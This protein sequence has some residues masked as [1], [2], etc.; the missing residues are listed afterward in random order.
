MDN[1]CPSCL[2][3]NY[4]GGVCSNCGYS[5]AA[6]PMKP[7]HLRPRSILNKRY[8]VGKFIGEGGFG[9]TYAGWDEK[10][11]RKVAIKEYYPSGY[12]TR[13][14]SDGKTVYSSGEKREDFFD[15]GKERFVEEAGRLK[16]FQGYPGIVEV[17]DCFSE[18]GTVYIVMEFVEGTTLSNVL[19]SMGGKMDEALVLEL[20]RPLIKSLGKMHETGLIHRDIAPDN[21]MIQPN[22]T[23]KLIDFGAAKEKD[24]AGQSSMAVMKHGYSPEEQYG[25]NRTRQGAWT[26]VYALCATIYRAIEG[27]APPDA[28]DRMRGD[29]SFKGFTVS[30]KP[31][32]RYAV[33]KGLEVSPEKRLQSMGEL[34]DYLYNGKIPPAPP[35]PEPPMPEPPK[36]EPKPNSKRLIAILSAIGGVAV[37]VI[38]I[39]AAVI[40]HNHIIHNNNNNNNSTYTYH[41]QTPP[42]VATPTQEPTERPTAKPTEKPT[43]KPTEKPTQ[44]PSPSPTEEKTPEPSESPASKRT[45]T[46]FSDKVYE[47]IAND[48]YSEIAMGGEYGAGNGFHFRVTD[49]Q[50]LVTDKGKS[51]LAVKVTLKNTNSIDTITVD[52]YDFVCASI[53]GDTYEDFMTSAMTV[54]STADGLVNIDFPINVVAG[55]NRTVVFCYDLPRNTEMAVFAYA[56]IW[57]S[58]NDSRTGNS[59]IYAYTASESDS[60]ATSAPSASPDDYILPF[61][62]DRALTDA[63]LRGLTKDQLRLARNEIYARYGRQFQ[64][65][66]LQDYFNSKKWYQDLPKLPLGTEPTLSKLELSNIDLIKQYEEAAN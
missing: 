14:T 18:N 42:P 64:D 49:M 63:D 50:P 30:V 36:P 59:F 29:A 61:S 51:Y 54:E 16:K 13:N 37:L 33:T 57:G 25:T 53:Y 47:D 41:D 40:I 2:T 45:A 43:Q 15:K 35:A 32:T 65:Q 46:T 6:T 34:A 22:G 44:K 20:M 62:S 52:E 4:S 60:S 12:V 8:F 21:I 28:L 5:D 7:H 38:V 26:D 9:I 31:V 23:V 66:G 27:E 11:N 10:M 58:I 1:L 39:V 55:S 3:H 19:A 48:N 17:L 56:N 24:T